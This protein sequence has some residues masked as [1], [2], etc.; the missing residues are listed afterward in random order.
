MTLI[1]MALTHL[2]YSPY[3]G[4]QIYMHRFVP[5]HEQ[6]MYAAMQKP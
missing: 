4:R 5:I 1:V 2:L 3:G 6:V